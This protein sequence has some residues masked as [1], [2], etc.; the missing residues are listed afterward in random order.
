M[1]ADL[2]TG[3]CQAVPPNWAFARLLVGVMTIGCGRSGIAGIVI[4]MPVRVLL[5]YGTD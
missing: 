1:R 5:L 2:V 3:P 4:V